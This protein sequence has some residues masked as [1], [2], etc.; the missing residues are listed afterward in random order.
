MGFDCFLM[1][2]GGEHLNTNVIFFDIYAIKIEFFPITFDIYHSQSLLVA[3]A[4]YA[5][6]WM[7]TN[8]LTRRCIGFFLMR[9]QKGVRIRT[10]FFEADLV[11]F[12]TVCDNYIL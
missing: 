9:S 12:K 1:C 2:S 8:A 10:A 11:T 5:T 4:I 3:D 6:D 7:A